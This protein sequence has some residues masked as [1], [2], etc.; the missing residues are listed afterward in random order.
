MDLAKE[1]N[2][3]DM[4]YLFYY[5]I[6]NVFKHSFRMQQCKVYHFVYAVSKPFP[7]LNM[8]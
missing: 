8:I 7:R 1:V 3:L 5:R 6:K 2:G 4:H